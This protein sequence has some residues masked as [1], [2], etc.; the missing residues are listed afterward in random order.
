MPTD[1]NGFARRLP[2][3]E[4]SGK[5][6]RYVKVGQIDWIE[7]ENQYMRLHVQ[8]QSFLV[9]MRSMTLQSLEQRLDPEQFQRVHRSHIVNLDRVISLHLD[10]TPAKRFARLTDGSRVPV[11][12]THWERL[13]EAL[14]RL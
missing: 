7:A 9:R 5:R 6:I 3:T 4:S 8:T 12:Q 13:Q 10:D 1:S 11:S 14:T 2:V